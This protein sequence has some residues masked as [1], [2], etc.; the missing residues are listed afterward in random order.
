M[1]H[2]QPSEDGESYDS[3]SSEEE[4]EANE[5]HPK[6][7][8]EANLDN[9]LPTSERNTVIPTSEPEN[10]MA[11]A[12]NCQTTVAT[13]DAADEQ[14]QAKA[15]TPSSQILTVITTNSDTV[16]A[17]GDDEKHQN[18]ELD[19]SSSTLSLDSTE[20]CSESTSQTYYSS[21]NSS[22]VTP[23]PKPSAMT[24][25][26]QL[27]ESAVTLI[28]G[29]AES[30]PVDQLHSLASLPPSTE[31]NN[32]SITSG[33]TSSVKDFKEDTKGKSKFSNFFQIRK[34]SLPQNT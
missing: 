16:S 15:E 6:T 30:Q 18:G 14:E 9:K 31:S 4:L 1:F 27:T 25:E 8:T 2:V 23:E 29:E 28:S 24:Q 10:R 3:E 22:C 11:D 5:C 17:S 20:A 33:S 32:S 13:S 26:T 7:V 34:K 12:A 19:D 21:V